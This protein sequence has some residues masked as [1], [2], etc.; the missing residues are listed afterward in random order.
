M[1]KLLPSLVAALLLAGCGPIEAREQRALDGE[2]IRVVATIGMI[3]DAAERVGGERV[4]V[5][6][7]MG[8]GVDPHLYKASEGDVRR[9][10]RADVIFY[11]GLHLEAKMGDVLERSATQPRHRWPSPSDPA[12]ELLA[13]PAAVPGPVRPARVVRRRALEHAVEQ[14]RDR[15]TELDPAQRRDSTAANAAAYLRRAATSSTRWVARAGAAHP[16][17]R[18]RADHRPRRLR[19]LRPGVRHRGA[20]AAGDLHGGRGGRRRRAGLA[21][22][23]A[24]REIPAD[25]R[26]VAVSPRTIEAVRRPCGR[27]ASTWR[28]AARSS[29]TRWATRARRRGPTSGWCGT[30][31]TRI[32]EGAARMSETE[33]SGH[34]GAR[35]DGR[36]PQKPVLWDVDLEVRRAS[37]WRSSAR[38][39]PARAR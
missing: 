7:L 22:F 1:P 10:E 30:T 26:R 12:R 34:R 37:W 16:R 39:A 15:L 32:V 9:L 38:T 17:E 28:S 13:T 5:D 20:R 3:G 14:I 29:P 8:P 25:L 33:T 11:S 21:R 27:A 35:P 19:L 24:E 6:G 4:E 18:A 2:T 36:L 31:S 23:I